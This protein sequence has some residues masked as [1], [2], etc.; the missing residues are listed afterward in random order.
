MAFRIRQITRTAAGRDIVRERRI[1][2]AV[3]TVGRAAENDLHL[4]DLAVAPVHARIERLDDR[5]VRVT[6]ATSLE[7]EIDGRKALTADIDAA[8][9]AELGLGGHRITVAREDG[10]I[11]LTIER[12]E[13]LSDAS[14]EKDEA[15]VFSLAGLLPSRRASAW[16]LALLVL[17]A[18]LAVPIWT[19]AQHKPG[20][21]HRSIYALKAQHSWSSGPLSQAHHALEQNC[22]ACHRQAFVSVRDDACRSCH[23]DVHDHAPAA[24]IADARAQ[25]GLGGRILASFARAFNRPGPGAC[26]DCHVEHEGAGPMP[27]TRQA[28]CTDCHA[29]LKSRLGDTRLGN[30]ADFGKAH[31]QFTPAVMTTAGADPVIRRVSLDM[32]PRQETG[33]KFP[34]D[35]HLS[36]T[37][38]VAQ[39]ARRLAGRY[40]FGQSLQCKDCHQPTADGTRFQPV[41][42]ERSCG[43]CHSLAFE[44]IGGTVRTLRHG[45]VDQ[46]IADIRAYYRAGGP[47][48]MNLGGMASRQR[49][50]AY[51]PGGEYHAS[52]ANPV[53]PGSA[54][55]AIRAVF[56]RGGACYDCHS[57]TPPGTNGAANWT[58]TPVHQQMRF[59]LHGWFDHDAH[60]TEKCES[61][62]A[63]DQSRSASDL[64]LPG[65]KTC[66]NCHGGEGSQAKVPSSCAMCHSYH[67]QPGA[68]WRSRREIVWTAPP[69]D[70]RPG[71]GGG[72]AP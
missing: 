8:K 58:V 43:M 21:D 36:T 59:M 61:C 31:P 72:R 13:A 30:A 7:F 2:Q 6:A 20:E 54:D 14:E 27:P 51:A 53:R 32:N 66:R 62:H 23:V 34:H 25:P 11:V 60:R 44:K 12:V 68:P 50:G 69:K 47:S 4:P 18:F 22:E 45:P 39:M 5:R 28:F 19:F 57:I 56:S 29:T 37:N 52:F 70:G 55:G 3:L 16:V 71:G 40:G 33:L 67:Q 35:L 64:L 63:A 48:P 15:R 1:E 26:V 9:G 41:E 42:M 38:G 17:A 65:I 24:R 46:V 10:D 49:P